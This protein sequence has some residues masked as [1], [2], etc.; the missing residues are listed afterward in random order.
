MNR[1]NLLGCLATLVPT[2]TWLGA[3]AQDAAFPSKPI[4][5][6]A[7]SGAGTLID[8]AARVYA[9]R[10]SAHLKQ[11]VVVENVAGAAS[12][13]A[14]RQVQK[15]PADGYTLL[16]VANTL[17]TVPHLNAKAG[18]A[19]KD[20]AA[21]GEMVRSPVILVTSGS[22]P[23]KSVA[24]IVAAA[25]KAPGQ[26]SF[27]S[28]GVGTT[29]HLPVEMLA[30]QAGVSFTH[31]P[32]KGIA[33]A[34]PDVAAGRVSFLMAAATSVAELIRSGVLRPLAISADKRSK[35]FPD[36]PTL[37]ELGYP[38]A[39]FEL[40]IGAVVPAATPS[41]VKARLGEAM[42]AARANP[43][44]QARFEALGQEIS[45]IRS[46]EQFEAVLRS[47]EEKLAALIKAAGIVAD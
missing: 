20:F 1:R 4:R 7:G 10:M 37:K 13:L 14:I 3:K 19:V 36:V 31:L 2:S 8:Q 38:G 25:K 6:V 26:V 29:N 27:G 24:D 42:E 18:Y 40:W 33:A 12:L 5:I 23:F 15:A 9:D 21:V 17:V 45:A 34:V 32:Y 16:V 44:V 46:P 41:A 30:Q 43:E 39:T 35:R 47:D 22:S 11:T 28:S